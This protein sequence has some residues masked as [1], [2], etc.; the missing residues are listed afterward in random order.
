MPVNETPSKPLLDK[1]VE[2]MAKTDGNIPLSK[3]YA[4]FKD[5]KKSTIRGRINEAVGAKKNIVRTAK[6]QYMLLGAEIEALVEQSD[7]TKQLFEILKANIYYDLV[8]LD[9]PYNTGGQ[10]GGNRDLSNY[11]MIS[12]EEFQEILLKVEKMLRTEDSQLYFMIAGGSSSAHAANKYIR[13]FDESSLFKAAEGSYTKLNANGTQCNMG[14]YLMPAE[15]ILV[16][17]PN[18]KL[19]KPEETILDFSMVRP[20]LPRSGGYPT[21]KPVGML[22]QIIEQSTEVG[23]YMLDP[24]LGSG[25]SLQA[26]LEK[27]R[28]FHGIEISQEAIQNHISKKLSLFGEY[29]KTIQK[30]REVFHQGSLFEYLDGAKN[31]SNIITT[32]AHSSTSTLG[33]YS[34]QYEPNIHV[35]SVEDIARTINKSHKLEL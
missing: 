27:N 31:D 22:K 23:G 17:S 35:G 10:K 8:F 26:A 34:G 11:A 3:I 7:S 33:D 28:K 1:I 24:F 13:A 2:Y 5:E 19:L 6:G 12:P 30:E 21:E 4:T 16:F 32:I 14:K 15:K 25:N 20:P 9:I 18:G 29:Y